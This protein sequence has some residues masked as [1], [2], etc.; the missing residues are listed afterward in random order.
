MKRNVAAGALALGLAVAL[1]MA[2]AFAGEFEGVW[3]VTDTGGKAFEITLSADGKASATRESEGMKGTWKE[4][5]DS[6]AITWDTGWTTVIAKDGDKYTKTAFGKGKPLD[7][8]PDNS[9]PAEKVK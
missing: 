2:Q 5:G 3:K 6:V 8:P 9:S 4:V 7:G 1:P